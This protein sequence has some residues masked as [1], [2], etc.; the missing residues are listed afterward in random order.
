MRHITTGRYM[1]R[2]L[3]R[4]MAATFALTSI[5]L[6]TTQINMITVE[7][8]H[9]TLRFG[10][11]IAHLINILQYLIASAAIP[12][13]LQQREYFDDLRCHHADNYAQQNKVELAPVIADNSVGDFEASS[14]R[15]NYKLLLKL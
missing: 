3:A 7:K 2:G 10:S 15:L 4:D 14:L 6:L 8:L 5:I 11:F 12:A 9:C 13:S 1:V